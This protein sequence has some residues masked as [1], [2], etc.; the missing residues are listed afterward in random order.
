[1]AQQKE[2]RDSDDSIDQAIPTASVD[3]NPGDA[4]MMSRSHDPRTLQLINKTPG[5]IRPITAA[6]HGQWFA[7]IANGKFTNDGLIVDATA[8]AAPTSNNAVRLF[9]NGRVRLAISNTSG[10][11]GDYVRYSSGTSGS[12]IFVIDN[13]RPGWAIA[14]IAATFTGASANDAQACDLIEHQ[15]QGQSIYAFLE[16]R[17]VEGCRVFAS[18]QPASRVRVGHVQGTVS[19][20]NIRLIQNKIFSGAAT[21]IAFGGVCSLT[22]SVTRFK[23]VV[24]RSGGYGVRSCTV[25]KKHATS[26]TTNAVTIGLLRPITWTAGE[27]PVALLI[28]RSASNQSN[29]RIKNVRGPELIPQVGSWGI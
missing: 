13:R 20:R 25:T 11:K 15:L 10:Q 7:G 2:N 17:V 8:Y 23:W 18:A 21:S 24:A 3:I 19:A 12:Q 14:R 16:N 28:Q 1:M 9:K 26:F 22:S 4:V 29:A 27:V 5:R 6:F